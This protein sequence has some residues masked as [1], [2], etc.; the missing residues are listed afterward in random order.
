MQVRNQQ[1][2]WAGVMFAVIGVLAAVGALQ[3]SMG[4]AR[5]MGPAYFPFWLG[6]CLSVLGA[7]VSLRALSVNAPISRIVPTD[8]KTVAI[9]IGSVALAGVLLDFLGIFLTIFILVVLSSMAS[10]LFSWK[11]AI[12][13]GLSLTVFVW[14]AFIKALGLVFP[15]WPPLLGS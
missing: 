13:T 11:V 14:L 4:S 15:L 10:H 6:I 3:Y 2:F 9:L 7:G 12:A 5:D 1:D 8:L